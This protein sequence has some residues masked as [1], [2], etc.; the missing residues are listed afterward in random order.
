MSVM[1]DSMIFSAEFSYDLTPDVR[2]VSAL[3]LHSLEVCLSL[4]LGFA[5]LSHNRLNDYIL[6]LSGHIPG[7]TT[8]QIQE[9]VT[10]INANRNSIPAD[11]DVAVVVAD[12]VPNLFHIFLEQVSHVDFVR[13]VPREG[14]I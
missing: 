7:V 10:R 9:L 1:S 12:D 13:L 8:N 11:I 5:A 3:W 4:G 2:R 6:H 14:R